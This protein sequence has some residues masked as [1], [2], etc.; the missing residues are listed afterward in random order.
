MKQKLRE[1]EIELEKIVTEQR[2]NLRREERL[3]EKFRDVQRTVLKE[4]SAK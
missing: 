2:E 1:L 4:L 3:L